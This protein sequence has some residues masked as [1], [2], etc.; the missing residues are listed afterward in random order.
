MSHKV[1]Q[2][3]A[4]STTHGT[5]PIFTRLVGESRRLKNAFVKSAGLTLLLTGL[6]SL[7]LILFPQPIVK[8]ALGSQWLATA[9]LLPW[10]VAAGWVQGA[11][12]LGYNWLVSQRR[13]AMMN[14]H[15]L[16]SVGSMVGF[17]WWGGSQAGLMGA[18][19]GLFWS[20]IISWPVLGWEIHRAWRS[21]K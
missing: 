5:L 18:V 6:T 1:N 3:L 17:V 10:L 2:E 16:I 19:I 14:L 13:Y 11:T 21:L 7:P 15:A 4:K 12:T 20:R 9:Q 8:I